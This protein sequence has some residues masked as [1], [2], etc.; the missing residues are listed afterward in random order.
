ME[1]GP[2]KRGRKPLPPEERTKRGRKRVVHHEMQERKE[3]GAPPLQISFVCEGNDP[4]P[5]SSSGSVNAKSFNPFAD[6]SSWSS[7]AKERDSAQPQ[8]QPKEISKRGKMMALDESDDDENVI[9]RSRPRIDVSSLTG[10]KCI[11]ILGAHTNKTEWPR[12]TDVACW[13]C[14]FAFDGIPIS[15]PQRLDPRTKKL[16][17]CFGVFCSFNCAKRHLLTKPNSWQ[18]LQLLTFLHKK[19]LGNVVKI[20]AAPPSQVLER[21]GGYMSI[22]EYRK[23]FIVLP[24]QAEMFDSSVRRD[25]VVLMQQ[26][27]IPSFQI[28]HQSHNQQ[29]VTN[30]IQEKNVRR[31]KY[32]RT[33]PL[34]GSEN[35]ANSMGI[36]TA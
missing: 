6:H 8:V 3:Q 14:T 17:G 33:R 26:N 22:E 1:E 30:S 25:H 13:N 10:D 31:E 21:F 19:V 2:K 9:V 32:D 28:V 24:P 27:C 5:Q 16:V 34:P 7:R 18:Q 20:T 36:K 15:A 11:E 4:A 29:L 23:D 35:L 12:E